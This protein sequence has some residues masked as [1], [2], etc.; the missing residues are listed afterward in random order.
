MFYYN[1]L[2][3]PLAFTFLSYV[4]LWRNA[5]ER[6]AITRAAPTAEENHVI[7]S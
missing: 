7:A 5:A 4:L 2:V 6:P 3:T 1:A